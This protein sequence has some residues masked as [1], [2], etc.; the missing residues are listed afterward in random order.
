MRIDDPRFRIA[1]ARRIRYREGCDSAVAGHLSARA[2][3]RDDA[4]WISPFEYFD[5]TTPDQ[6]VKLSFGLEL[7]E[8]SWEPSPAAQFPAAIYAGKPALRS[9]IHT[10]SHWVS[11]FSTIELEA[12]GITRAMGHDLPV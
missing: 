9:V 11:V 10:H 12:L 7:L 8:G 3:D 1:A 6:V 2:D 4:F 5:E